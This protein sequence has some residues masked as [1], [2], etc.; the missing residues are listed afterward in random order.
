MTEGLV[1]LASEAVGGAV[2]AANDEFFAPASN[3]VK[4]HPPEWREGVY[5]DRGKW[6]DGWESRR[7]RSPG[8]DWCIIRLGI[9]GEVKRVLVDTTHFRGNYPEAC[10]LEACGVGLDDAL[11][12][13]TWE[14]LLPRSELKGDEVND[15]DVD[16]GRRVTHRPS[17]HLP[18]RRCRPS[19]GPGRSASRPPGGGAG[20]S[21]SPISPVPWSGEA[22]SIPV[23]TSSGRPMHCSGPVPRLGDVRRL[24]DPSPERRGERLGQGA[25]RAARN[26]TSGPGGHVALQGQRSGVGCGR[27]LRA[28]GERWTPI[29]ERRWVGANRQHLFEVEGDVEAALVRLD[30]FPDGGVA[31]FRVYGDSDTLRRRS[32]SGSATST[33]SSRMK[34]IAS[35]EQPAGRSAGWNDGRGTPFASGAA[36]LEAA[37]AGFRHARGFGLGGGLRR[38]PTDRGTVRRD[39]GTGAGDGGGDRHRS[40]EELVVGKQSGTRIGSGGPSSS[41]PKGGPRVRSSM[42]WSDA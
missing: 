31:R 4:A 8:H 7:R 3:L 41:P 33:R 1:D 6:M 10:S 38:P 25:A 14:G 5:T 21:D 42:H 11:P 32:R 16:G 40:E 17:Q 29:V 15:F 13:A 30:I 9:A 12:G 20:G 35:S 23:T 34:H 36:V 19:P 24:G 18:R 26:P 22:S 2:L 28:D 37:E 27:G 39:P